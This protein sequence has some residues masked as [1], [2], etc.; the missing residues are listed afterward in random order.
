MIKQLKMK[1]NG[2]KLRLLVLHA[3]Q[4]M[5]RGIDVSNYSDSTISM[6][7]EVLRESRGVWNSN[8]PDLLYS[9]LYYSYPGIS[10]YYRSIRTENCIEM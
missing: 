7:E 6:M 8:S 5:I 3:N 10:K 2:R 4:S 1:T 9:E